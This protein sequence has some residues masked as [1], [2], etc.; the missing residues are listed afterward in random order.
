MNPRAGTSSSQPRFT[1]WLPLGISKPTTSSSHLRLLYSSGRVALGK[2][3]V[4]A[5]LGLYLL[6]N[7][8]ASVPNGQLKTT[9]DH[10]HPVP[11]QLI[12]HGRQRLVVSDCSQSLQLTGLSKSL[13]LICQQQ[14]RLNYKRRVYS[15]HMKHIPPVPSLGD[16]GGCTTGSYKTPTALG[17]AA[18]T[19]SYSSSTQYIEKTQRGCQNLATKK[20]DPN[21]R[22]DQNSRKEIK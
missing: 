13:P 9:S 16:R 14:P 5:D 8:R 7:S 18:K 11:A 20:H 15:A 21:E 6:G 3:Q 22:R 2:T 19:G 10:H 12:L 17:H 4:R 1:A